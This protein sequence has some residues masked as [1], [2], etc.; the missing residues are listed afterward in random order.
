MNR[1]DYM[2]D[3]A[4][5][6]SQA[7]TNKEAVIFHCFNACGLVSRKKKNDLQISKLVDDGIVG[8]GF[9]LAYGGFHSTW[10]DNLMALVNKK[11]IGTIDLKVALEL[12]AKDCANQEKQINGAA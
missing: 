11:R 5:S 12:L 10:V 4:T 8:S 3:I 9:I 6:E 2:A 7:R 1:F